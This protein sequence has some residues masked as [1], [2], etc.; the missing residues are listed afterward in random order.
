[1]AEVCDKHLEKL[2]LWKW[3]LLDA[4]SEEIFLIHRVSIF[5]PTYQLPLDPAVNEWRLCRGV[6]KGKK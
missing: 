5:L 6:L 4:L 2:T 1:M 3:E